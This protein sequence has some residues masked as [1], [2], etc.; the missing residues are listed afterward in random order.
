M[1]SSLKQLLVL[2]F[3]FPISYQILPRSCSFK[4]MRGKASNCRSWIPASLFFSFNWTRFKT[5]K[6]TKP[7]QGTKPQDCKTLLNIWGH[8]IWKYSTNFELRNIG[9]MFLN[10]QLSLSKLHTEVLMFKNSAAKTKAST[11]R[12]YP[13]TEISFLQQKILKMAP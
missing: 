12:S 5:N 4:K 2:K 13:M 1:L 11:K 9:N 7:Q 8:V 6:Q 10:T 3:V